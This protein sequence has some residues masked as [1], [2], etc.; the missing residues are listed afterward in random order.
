MTYTSWRCRIVQIYIFAGGRTAGG[1][2]DGLMA[3]T[4]K[5]L[6]EKYVTCDQP[7]C[8]HSAGAMQP[9]DQTMS[10]LGTNGQL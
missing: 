6:D 4:T 7:R 1:P 8:Q 5:Q 9:P 2:S 10:Q 3:V